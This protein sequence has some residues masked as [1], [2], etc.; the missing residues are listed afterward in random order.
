MKRLLL[1]TYCLSLPALGCDVEVDGQDLLNMLQQSGHRPEH[2]CFEADLSKNHFF[3]FPEQDC[4]VIFDSNDWLSSD[5]QV[6]RVMGN[7]TFSLKRE[8]SQLII[9]I[10]AAGGFRLGTLVF[11][12]DAEDCNDIQLEDILK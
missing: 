12:T 9:T 10:D 8:A 3:A 11:S 5:W 7:G 2:S 1:A 4:E 6:K